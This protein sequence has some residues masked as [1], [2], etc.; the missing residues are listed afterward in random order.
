MPEQDAPDHT[1]DHDV[2]EAV[3]VRS[4]DESDVAMAMGAADEWLAVDGAKWAVDLEEA[5]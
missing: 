5:R 4:D 3:F 2:A 1:A